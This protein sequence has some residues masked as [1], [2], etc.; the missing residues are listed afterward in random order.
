MAL[1]KTIK[2]GNELDDWLVRFDICANSNGWNNDKKASKIRTFL[3]GVLVAYLEMADE[4]KQI[5]P[6][7]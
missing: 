3:E 5:T 7:W 6:H 2:D 1:P 4:D